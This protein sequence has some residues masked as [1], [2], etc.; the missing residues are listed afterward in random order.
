M[1][2][3]IEK[4]IILSIIKYEIKKMEKKIESKNFLNVENINFYSKLLII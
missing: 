1:L 3:F 4:P 2:F